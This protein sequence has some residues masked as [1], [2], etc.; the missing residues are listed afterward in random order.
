MNITSSVTYNRRGKTFEA[1]LNGTRIAEADTRLEAEALL[2]EAAAPDLASR[3]D[4]V[5]RRCG[6]TS[7]KRCHRGAKLLLAG[8]VHAN[9]EG[10]IVDSETTED[11]SYAVWFDGGWLCECTDWLN[12]YAGEKWGAPFVES[13]GYMCK[14]AWACKLSIRRRAK[15]EQREVA[16]P[17]A[18]VAQEAQTP[19]AVDFTRIGS[20][21]KTE[22]MT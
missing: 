11:A 8:H 17:A 9:S 19:N 18:L 15:D 2:I 3:I 14:H 21:V 4:Y 22:V 5:R 16:S 7:A 10:W 20:Q 13:N 12:G 1:R 6:E